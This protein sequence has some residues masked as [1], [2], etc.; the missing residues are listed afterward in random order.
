MKV[1]VIPDVHQTTHW[2]TA[3]NYGL[4]N[5]F[6]KIIQVGDWFDSWTNDW[7]DN[8]PITNFQNAVE[9]SKKEK[10]F[11]I[12][13]G[14][15]DFSYLAD[16]KCSG[17]QA[18]HAKEI[19][20]I[21]LDTAD[22]VNVAKQYDKWV[23]SHAGVS[24]VWADNN[25]VKTVNDI[26]E[27]FHKYTV[28]FFRFCLDIKTESDSVTT[29][30]DYKRFIDNQNLEGEYSPKKI[31]SLYAKG[32]AVLELM[33]KEF[34]VKDAF[35]ALQFIKK[36]KTFAFF[37]WN[38]YGDDPCQGPLWIRPNSLFSNMK[39][40]KQCVGHTEHM[41][42]LTDGAKQLIVAD[43]D[44]HDTVVELDTKTNESKLIKLS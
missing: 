9:A 36:A 6:D 8:K 30:V 38:C 10:K 42:V 7:T 18:F 35:D 24:K 16:N 33:Q 3:L 5:G 28:P 19:K 29:V 21:L 31:E 34:G 43:S 27:I 2:E 41:N 13:L 17:Y 39:F 40:K 4:K 25:K 12:L 20:Q 11:D 44:T 37:G 32:E 26:N 23:F 14:N 1:L 22:Y 15:H